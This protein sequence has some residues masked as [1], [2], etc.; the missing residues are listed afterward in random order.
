MKV[1]FE[2]FL[3]KNHSWAVVGQNLAR[4]LIQQGHQIDLK[5]TNGYEHFPQDLQPFIKDNLNRNYD[6]QISYTSMTNFNKYLSHGSKNRFGIWNYEFTAL[7]T[8]FAKYTQFLDKFL[9]SS[10]F[11]KDIFLQNG[12]P[13]E[14]MVMV[15]HGFYQEQYQTAEPMDLKIPQKIKILAN[16]AQP[17]LRKNLPGLL[18]AYGK[19]FKKQD[20]VCLVLK[21]VEKKPEQA[22]EVRFSQCFAEFKKKFPQ[23]AA[24]R[25]LNEFIPNIASLY[26]ACQIVFTMT[27]AECFWLPGLEGLASGNVVISPRYGGQLDFL[28]DQNSLL[29]EGKLVRATPAACYWKSSVYSGWFQPDMEDAVKKLRYAVANYDQLKLFSKDVLSQYTWGNVAKQIVELC[30]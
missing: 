27:H 5:S 4:A 18:E 21:V 11:S 10:N 24:I 3:G 9:P 7:P 12:V 29:I 14:K 16:V 17:H 6:M 25:I 22:F 1:C 30:V 20:D 2:Q 19:A 13:A 8:G 28:N 15:P 23:H 26:K